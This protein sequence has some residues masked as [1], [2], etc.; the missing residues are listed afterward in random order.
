VKGASTIINQHGKSLSQ[1]LLDLFPD[2]GL[3]RAKFSWVTSK[4]LCL[5]IYSLTVKANLS[6]VR[7]K[8]RRAQGRKDKVIKIVI[9]QTFYF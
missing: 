3:Q 2:I 1:T 8:G 9:L 5:F 7:S 4:F 6:Y